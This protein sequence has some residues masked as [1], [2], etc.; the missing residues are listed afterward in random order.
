MSPLVSAAQEEG[1]SPKAMF[2][3]QSS[4]RRRSN[5]GRDP[6]EMPNSKFD[7]FEALNGVASMSLVKTSGIYKQAQK[8]HHHGHH[9]VPHHNRLERWV[10]NGVIG[11]VCGVTSF[12]MK[13]VVQFLANIRE[14]MI[15]AESSDIGLGFI[16][17][18]WFTVVLLAGSLVLVSAAIIIYVEPNA[19]G[20]GIPETCAFLNGVIIPKTFSLSV[21]YAKFASCGLAVGSGLPVGP[22]GPMIHMGSIIGSLISQGQV[23]NESLADK[24][25]M[26]RNVSDRR[27]F[28]AAG[29]AGGVA[30]VSLSK[31]RYCFHCRHRCC[32][33]LSFR[34]SMC[35]YE[36][37]SKHQ[38][39]IQ[40]VFSCFH[41]A[42][43]FSDLISLH[44]SL[45]FALFA[46]LPP[47]PP[48]HSS[49]RPPHHI[50]PS[51]GLLCPYRRPAVCGGGG[52][53]P[54]GREPRHASLL[55]L[56][57]GLHHGRSPDLKL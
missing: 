31:H 37:N 49:V 48:T 34:C 5:L 44:N 42:L 12:L 10:V 52:G 18:A 4:A 3:R 28:M 19:A 41:F 56:R 39:T 16:G 50:T 36:K 22:E 29:V 51:S 24:I 21:V 1:K 32:W 47:P 14:Q 46:R 6:E 2:R 15:T 13:M 54:L 17:Y 25:K 43:L 33:L 57:C 45:L 55:L 40:L 11:F 27:D 35:S 9:H 26:F 20:S 23:L 38:T 8:D 7:T 53:E 30:A